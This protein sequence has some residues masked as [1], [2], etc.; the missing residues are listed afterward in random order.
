MADIKCGEFKLISRNWNLTFRAAL[1]PAPTDLWISVFHVE[2]DP[3]GAKDVVEE[4]TKVSDGDDG[5]MKVTYTIVD[6]G[7]SEIRKSR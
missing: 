6:T 3:V 1:T 2:E 7:N 5:L 4:F